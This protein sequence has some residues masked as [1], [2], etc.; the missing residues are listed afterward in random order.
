MESEAKDRGGTVAIE[1]FE[2][3]LGHVG[4]WGRYQLILLFLFFPCT[5]MLAHVTYTP[6]L[7]LYTPEHHCDVGG[8]D[9]DLAIPIDEDTGQRS[10]CMMY[11]VEVHTQCREKSKMQIQMHPPI[12][13]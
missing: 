13:T 10:R 11:D 8:L 9:P 6:V 2:D 3:I 4:G 1:D 5:M 12:R 7:I